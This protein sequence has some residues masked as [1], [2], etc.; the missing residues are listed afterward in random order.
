MKRILVG[1]DDI[2]GP[3]VCQRGGGVWIP[4]GGSVAIGQVEGGDLVG[5]VTYDN[6]NGANIVMHVAGD[7]GKSWLSRRFIW[8]AFYY[9][10]IQLGCR[11]V[12][13]FTASTNT[14]ALKFNDDLGFVHEAT[15][16]DAH[17]S[18]DL[19]IRSMTK[20]QCRWLSLG[21]NYAHPSSPP[22]DAG[23]AGTGLPAVGTNSSALG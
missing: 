8:F 14:Q 21:K 9:P 7:P 15:L 10:F 23:S 20:A 3:W 6:F 1:A 18:G 22:R 13:T 5:G 12:S 16:K 19:I 11:R 17:P 4:G 2:V